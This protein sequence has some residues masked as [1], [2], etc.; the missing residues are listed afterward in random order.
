MGSVCTY[1]PSSKKT[2]RSV[3][4]IPTGS[5]LF[6][7]PQAT[8]ARCFPNPIRSQ[9]VLVSSPRTANQRSCSRGA[10]F[11]RCL[12]LCWCLLGQFPVIGTYPARGRAPYLPLRP[13][14]HARALSPFPMRFQRYSKY[15]C[16]G[17]RR[18]VYPCSDLT[19]KPRLA[20]PDRRFSAEM[21][22]RTW[23]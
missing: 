8:S 21:V 13:H 4:S 3:R 23:R 11:R 17:H 16:K 14:A 22:S 7:L 2:T 19:W 15:G 20:R 10:S 6:R 1:A 9:T 12:W 5:G 18:S